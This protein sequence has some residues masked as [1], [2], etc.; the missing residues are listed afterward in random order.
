VT[1]TPLTQIPEALGKYFT[2]N[3]AGVAAFSPTNAHLISAH[4]SLIDATILELVLPHSSYPAHILFAVLSDALSTTP[5]EEVR[6]FSQAVVDGLGGLSI[7]IKMRAMLEGPLLAAGAAGS[8]WIQ[9]PR[10]HPEEV[11]AFYDAVLKSA[12]VTPRQAHSWSHLVWPLHRTKS[13]G[14]LQGLWEAIDAVRSS[15]LISEGS[16]T[17]RLQAYRDVTSC[18]VDELWQLEDDRQPRPQW[19]TWQIPELVDYGDISSEEEE[20]AAA[21]ANGGAAAGGSR[22]RGKSKF[23]SKKKDV[24]PDALVRKKRVRRMGDPRRRAITAGQGGH[25]DDMPGLMDYSSSSEDSDDLQGEEEDESGK[26]SDVEWGSDVESDYDPHEKTV[27]QRLMNKAQDP[28]SAGWKGGARKK[29]SNPFIR[30]LSNLRGTSGIPDFG[31]GFV[32]LMD[33]VGMSIGRMFNTDPTLRPARM[34]PQQAPTAD[35]RPPSA[36]ATAM[37]RTNVQ[38]NKFFPLEIPDPA[39][40]KQQQ[41]PPPST[42]SKKSEVEDVDDL[43]FLVGEKEKVRV[44]ATDG[45]DATS[46]A[47]DDAPSA[48]STKAPTVTARTA[49]GKVTVKEVE[50]EDDVESEPHHFSLLFKINGALYHWCCR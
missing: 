30:L 5:H 43:P 26:N 11:D 14:V 15:L 35:L 3:D 42:S 1:T 45:A 38:T 13:E 9:A 12:A 25:D 20:D 40:V 28:A 22:D 4:R 47:V 17:D 18:S 49:A 24:R 29:D 27:L 10:R 16:E 23:K 36:T 48:P 50:D 19:S 31:Y 21:N 6:K 37:A 33:W 2:T 32:E 34:G 44:K 8:A 39:K 7:L 41:P 46:P